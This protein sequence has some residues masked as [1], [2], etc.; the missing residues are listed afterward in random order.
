MNLVKEM[1]E[2]S[3]R[4]V[5][6]G[7]ELVSLGVSFTPPSPFFTHEASIAFAWFNDSFQTSAQFLSLKGGVV[8]LRC[9][10]QTSPFVVSTFGPKYSIDWYISGGLR[11]HLIF[12]SNCSPACGSS[13]L[14]AIAPGVTIIQAGPK[15]AADLCLSG[16][17]QKGFP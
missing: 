7:Y 8:N 5:P 10:C 9:R 12:K 4:F 15:R 13:R 1:E 14:T 2:N 16:N 6:W 3:T 17:C 11:K